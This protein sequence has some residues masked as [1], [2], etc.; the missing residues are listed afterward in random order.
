MTELSPFGQESRLSFP[1]ASERSV[2]AR[3]TLLVRS[4]ALLTLPRGPR[5]AI[6]GRPPC[7]GEALMVNAPREW[8]QREGPQTQAQRAHCVRKPGLDQSAWLLGWDF[9]RT[10]FPAYSSRVPGPCSYTEEF[11]QAC[12]THSKLC[13]SFVPGQD[14]SVPTSYSSLKQAKGN[15]LTRK[16]NV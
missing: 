12:E 9:Q 6:F 14:S 16:K 1:W 15:Y 11:L 5:E 4:P 8:R 7:A 13:L 3:E 2:S 10:H